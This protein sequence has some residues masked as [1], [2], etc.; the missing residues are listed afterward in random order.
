[1]RCSVSLA[2]FISLWSG[3]SHTLNTRVH[4]INT[5]MTTTRRGKNTVLQ[6]INFNREK[7][8]R[9]EWWERW[10]SAWRLC[11]AQIRTFF[12][13]TSTIRRATVWCD[14]RMSYNWEVKST[15]HQMCMFR[16][17][18]SHFSRFLKFSFF[19]IS[20][21]IC[22]L[23]CCV[24]FPYIFLCLPPP[25]P[26]KT[27]PCESI[28]LN[29]LS[30]GVKCCNGKN[31]LD[32]HRSGR[33]VREWEV[34]GGECVARCIFWAECEWEAPWIRLLLSIYHIAESRDSLYFIESTR[35]ALFSMENLRQEN[36][37][38][39]T[40]KYDKTSVWIEKDKSR[41]RRE[42]DAMATKDTRIKYGKRKFE[43]G[44]GD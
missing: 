26:Q 40:K 37:I 12:R 8:F 41:Q 33:V 5:E 43:F 22:V 16:R 31:P 30:D 24:L 10:A 1:M 28:G 29:R 42:N 7:L 11:K 25:S 2:G 4:T 17:I 20:H 6:L 44:F 38:D 13:P 39:F 15:L 3:T 21:P 35:F 23:L 36:F 27:L 34:D 18:K 32:E 9:K 14:A 19:T